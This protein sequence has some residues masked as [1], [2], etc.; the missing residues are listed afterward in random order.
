MKIKSLEWKKLTQRENDLM[1]Q[2]IVGIYT[3]RPNVNGTF[4]LWT[5]GMHYNDSMYFEHVEPAKEFSQKDFESRIRSVLDDDLLDFLKERLKVWKDLD[6]DHRYYSGGSFLENQ[7]NSL[8]IESHIKELNEIIK[9]V[10][11]NV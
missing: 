2:S 5:A 3:I 4:R 8:K 11:S 7:L 1:A 6:D 9:R 10:E